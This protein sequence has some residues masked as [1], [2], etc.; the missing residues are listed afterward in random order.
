M[1]FTPDEPWTVN[2]EFATDALRFSKFATATLSPVVWSEPAATAKF[3]AVMPPVA[4][5][6]RVSTPVPPSIDVSVPW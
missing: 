6:T 5:S 2:A 1:T 3:T 4:A